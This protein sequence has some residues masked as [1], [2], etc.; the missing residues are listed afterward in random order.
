MAFIVVGIC[1]VALT[2]GWALKIRNEQNRIAFEKLSIEDQGLSLLVSEG[3]TSCHQAGSPFRGPILQ[4]LF[5]R[6][7]QLA[8]GSTVV[9]DYDYLKLSIAVPGADIVFGYQNVMPSYKDR[10]TAK[11]ID[12]L[13][14]AMK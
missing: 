4:K 8:D 6:S 7:V 10:L 12:A 9:A 1:V 13:I 3:C 11:Q 5:G 14:S 2:G